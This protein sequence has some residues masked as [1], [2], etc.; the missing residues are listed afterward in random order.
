MNDLQK[1]AD[2]NNVVQMPQILDARVLEKSVSINFMGSKLLKVTLI[3]IAPFDVPIN[4]QNI[5]DTTVVAK[6]DCGE[7]CLFQFKSLIDPNAL[8]ACDR[9]NAS[10]DEYIQMH[11]IQTG[12]LLDRKS[13]WKKLGYSIDQKVHSLI[14][15]YL[16]DRSN[17]HQ[18]RLG[19]EFKPLSQI[20]I[21]EMGIP[22]YMYLSRLCKPAPHPHDVNDQSYIYQCLCGG[23]CYFNS[24]V[25][26]SFEPLGMCSAC[27]TE[28]RYSFQDDSIHPLLK[29]LRFKHLWK[30]MLLKFNYPYVEFRYVWEDYFKARKLI[31]K[32]GY[33]LH[34][35][36]Y[37]HQ[38]YT[39]LA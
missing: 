7:Y 10:L 12:Y 5:I 33:E 16:L 1:K 14:F 6:C 8:P 17:F 20:K 32:Q 38:Y 22:K 26:K 13:A 11:Y 2:F 34:F 27:M 29:Q 18:I 35:S 4:R 30:K 25:L 21:D 9:C 36:D 15:W 24:S 23:F 31:R 37:L 3:G 28:L 39:A 19:K